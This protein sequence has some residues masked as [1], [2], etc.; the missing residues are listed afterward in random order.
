MSVVVIPEFQK[1]LIQPPTGFPPTLSPNAPLPALRPG[2]ILVRVHAVALNPTDYKMPTSFPSP[3]AACG[4]DFAGQIAAVAADDIS[5]PYQQQQQQQQSESSRQILKPGDAVFGAVHGS[6][7]I[8][9]ATGAFAEF[10]AADAALVCKVPEGMTWEQAA[11]WG[12][13]G[14]HTLGIALWE[15]ERGLGL[16]WPWGEYQGKAEEGKDGHRR[17]NSEYV[18]VN[19]GATATGTLAVQLLRL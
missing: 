10:V 12:G 9:H 16:K 4:C 3:G 15:N 11:A 2:Q 8:D 5:N 1:V 18:L 6:N 19:G 13:I 14:W 17:G 7:P